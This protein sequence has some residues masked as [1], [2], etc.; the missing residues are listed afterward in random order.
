MAAALAHPPLLRDAAFAR[1][2]LGLADRVLGQFAAAAPAARREEGFRVLRQ[3]LGYALSVLVAAEPEAGFALLERWASGR[4]PDVVWVL[5]ENL[6]KKR[7]GGHADR[8]SRLS[9]RLGGK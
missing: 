6:K 7:L 9:A 4:D 2:A 5:R 3:G 8:V 1:P